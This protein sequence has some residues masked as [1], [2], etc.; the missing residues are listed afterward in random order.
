MSVRGDT[1]IEAFTLLGALAASTERIA[2]GTLV[3]N[4]AHRQP[5]ITAVAAAS[6]SA[7]SARPFFLGLGA[8][9]SPTSPWAAELHAVGQP[10]EPLLPRRHARVEHV[11]ETCRRLW[12]DDRGPELATVPRPAPPVEI[13]VGVGS[14]ALAVVAGRLA[15]AVNVPWSHSRRDD[16]LRAARAAAEGAARARALGVT[17]YLPWD[18]GLLD[19]DHPQRRAMAAAGVD[20]VILLVRHAATEALAVGPST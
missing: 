19:P 5:A 9:A 3:L 20:R 14:L 2:L 4:V 10:I 6:V 7:V 12:A 16:L 11:I 15:D 8:G 18:A 13:H 1:M 17:T